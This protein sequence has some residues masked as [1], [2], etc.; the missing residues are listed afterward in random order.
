[1]DYTALHRYL[2]T[3]ARLP[4]RLG[5]V[6]CVTFVAEALKEGWGKDY[7]HELRYS[8]RRSAVRRLRTSGGLANAVADILGPMCPMSH[9]SPGD[10]VFIRSPDSLGIIIPRPGHEPYIAVKGHYVVHR[11]V[12]QPEYQGWKIS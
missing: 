12:I 10:V 8:D 4:Q 3:Q 1:M 6:D 7:L 11:L 9:L 2:A 5:V